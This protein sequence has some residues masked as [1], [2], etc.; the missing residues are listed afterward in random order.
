[1]KLVQDASK[2]SQ[3]WL[4][5]AVCE[6]EEYNKDADKC[7]K[8][9]SDHRLLDLTPQRMSVC[10]RENYSSGG[11]SG[12]RRFLA[13]RT[14]RPRT[15]EPGR[16]GPGLKCARVAHPLW[17]LGRE[18]T[19]RASR[20]TQFPPCSSS[21]VCLCMGT[22]ALHFPFKLHTCQHIHDPCPPMLTHI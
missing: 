6:G 3:N 21:C 9:A 12:G 2:Q 19:R 11:R 16:A 5:M 14:P 15:C 1:M 8:S 10:K 13:G 17:H 22:R 4:Q 7:R 18:D 20:S